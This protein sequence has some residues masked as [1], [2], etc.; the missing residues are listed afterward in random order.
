MP[1]LSLSGLSSSAIHELLSRSYTFD[2]IG[3]YTKREGLLDKRT[4]LRGSSS[5]F[6]WDA[7]VQPPS[8]PPTIST[9]TL[10]TTA[11]VTC[12][13]PPEGSKRLIDEL[14]ETFRQNFEKCLMTRY[15]SSCVTQQQE[16][17]KWPRECM[18]P[19]R[20]ETRNTSA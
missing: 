8:T 14:R 20:G 9:V 13:G 19:A 4:S 17:G 3:A 1:L 10:S 6:V 16:N 15:L 12:D 18:S 5:K 2:A 11:V 7:P